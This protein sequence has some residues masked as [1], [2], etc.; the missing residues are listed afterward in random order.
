MLKNVMLGE[1]YV[2]VSYSI[3]FKKA[4]ININTSWELNSHLKKYQLDPMDHGHID[5]E[6]CIQISLY[7][8][9]F[10]FKLC[11]AWL[12]R[13]GNYILGCSET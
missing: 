9:V 13:L 1:S 4:G 11:D 3:H 2:T 6:T 12:D 10:S 5:Q 8:N 7:L